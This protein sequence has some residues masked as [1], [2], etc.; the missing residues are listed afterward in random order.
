[1][2]APAHYVFYSWQSDLPGAHNRN[3]IE[4]A[5]EAA[6]KQLNAAAGIEPAP[7]AEFGGELALDKDTQDVP[8]SPA[9][10]DTIIE[11]IK[12]CSVFVGDLSFVAQSLPELV[13]AGKP[14]RFVPNPNVTIE[15]TYALATH[16][17][18]H[19]IAVMNEA[20][21]GDPKEHVPFNL[22]HRKFPIRYR[23][24]PDTTPEEKARVKKEL[25][26]N[27][28][29]AIRL[30][31]KE[32]PATPAANP[33]IGS[34]FLPSEFVR[35]AAAH[36]LII[37]GPYGEEIEPY[38]IPAR[39]MI[40]LRLQPTVVVPEFE[41]EG[42]AFLAASKGHLRPMAPLETSGQSQARN[43]MGGIVYE[44]PREGKLRFL[45]QLF[46]SKELYGLDAASA[47][48]SN[49]RRVGDPYP[50][51]QIERVEESFAVTL[52]N[53]LTFARDTLQLPGPF[54]VSAHVYDIMNFTVAGRR[55]LRHQFDWAETVEPH[56][57]VLGVLTPCYTALWKIFT[58]TRPDTAAD[59]LERLLRETST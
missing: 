44:A 24:G 56:A 48:V 58:A 52:R 29:Q 46:V 26:A 23:L 27:L 37:D 34:N 21:G 13:N 5:I 8:G 4:G 28:V 32:R 6:L 25:V 3:F 20:Y 18:K 12:G 33:F 45:T 47:G 17:D 9:I 49:W 35:Q 16:G 51:F 15:Y 50:V 31:L 36:E 11:K 30:V 43:A 2:P 42:D 54:R 41:S 1:M 39:C 59:A 55:C 53:Y 14:V 38:V 22:R 57:S 40:S 7:R 10:T 19:V